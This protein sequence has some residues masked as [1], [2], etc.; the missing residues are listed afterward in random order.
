MNNVIHFPKGKRNSLPQTIEEVIE[1]VENTR[2]EH[3]EMFMSM[4][5]PFIFQKA[6]D[7]G[8]DISQDSCI[9]TNTFFVESLNAMLCK[10][11]GMYHPIHVVVDDIADGLLEDDESSYET[12]ETE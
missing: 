1:T 7:E 8:F 2:R 11:A 10:A 4:M 5:I 3:I 9:K 6:C 12:T